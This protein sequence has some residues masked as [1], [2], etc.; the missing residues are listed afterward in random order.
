MQNLI[1]LGTRGLHFKV[2]YFG[3]PVNFKTQMAILAFLYCR[4][5]VKTSNLILLQL[6]LSED[7]RDQF[8][9]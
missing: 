1:S 2:G 3:N 5:F 7:L 4:E 9:H 6:F 8:V